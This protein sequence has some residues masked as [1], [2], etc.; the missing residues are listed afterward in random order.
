MVF[1]LVTNSL[2]F[3]PSVSQAK[4]DSRNTFTLEKELPIV[5]SSN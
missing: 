4:I 1:D 2:S 3:P 5:F